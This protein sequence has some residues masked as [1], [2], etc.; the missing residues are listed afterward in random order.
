MYIIYIY[1]CVCVY[2]GLEISAGHQAMSNMKTKT[3]TDV[4]F[5]YY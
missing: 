1:V 3:S 2:A 5:S 4:K